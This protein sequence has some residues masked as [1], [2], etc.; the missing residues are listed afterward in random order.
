MVSRPDQGQ[1]HVRTDTDGSAVILVLLREHQQQWQQRMS[2]LTAS[3]DH[4]E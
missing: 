4:S 1:G 3:I 2:P